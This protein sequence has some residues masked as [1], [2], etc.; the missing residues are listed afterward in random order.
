MSLLTYHP[1]PSKGCDAEFKRIRQ[2]MCSIRIQARPFCAYLYYQFVKANLHYFVQKRSRSRWS[3]FY[4]ACHWTQGLFVQTP[5]K[6]ID[7]FKGDKIRCRT[8]FGVQ[9]K[10]CC[11]IMWHVKDP[12]EVLRN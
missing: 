8:S 7:F 12:C 6:M 2:R 5:P 11:K 3:V 9:V 10:P 1:S 4:R